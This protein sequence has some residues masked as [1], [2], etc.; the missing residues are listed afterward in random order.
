MKVVMFTDAYYPRINGVAVSVKSFADSLAILGHKVLI[1]ASDYT[2]NHIDENERETFFKHFRYE[3]DPNGNKNLS[4]LRLPADKIIFSKE[5]RTVRL[6]Q[7]YIIKAE[8]D[9]FGPDVV[10]VNSEFA[11]GWFGVTYARHRHV[12]L[13]FTFH[14]L[15]EDY[16]ANYVHFLPSSWSQK[17][18][19]KLVKFYLKRADE[20]IVPTARIG[21]VIGEYGVS[22]PYDI[23]PTGIP[24]SVVSFNKKKSVDFYKKLYEEFPQLEGK[25]IL[26][27]IGRVVKEKNL[28]F[29]FDVLERV[30]PSVPDAVLLFV[31]GG[32]ELEAL[33]AA[34]SDRGLSDRA[35]F[36]GYRERGDLVY[37]YKMASV[38]T[39]PSVTET[40]GLVTVEAMLTGLPVVAIGEMGTLDVMQGDN[41]GF[42]VGNDADEFARR[43]IELLSDSKLHSKKSKEAF[44]WAQ[45]WSMKFLAPRLVALYKKGIKNHKKGNR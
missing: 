8:V 22:R 27:Y 28:P 17:L 20:I 30:L 9:K 10:H 21:G 7:W 36:A 45:K 32:P 11:M 18:G 24:S 34:A 35:I 12:A 31:G 42:M 5:D 19:K 43:T 37:F 1:V 40:Q 3:D 38:F 13:I 26:L 4:I 16:L 6:N 2:N 39:F 23:L 41:G 14:T 33:K 29:L 15:W 25:R 44:E